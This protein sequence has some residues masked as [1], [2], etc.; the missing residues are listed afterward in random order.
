M[1][2]CMYVLLPPAF[3][4]DQNQILFPAP[5]SYTKTK[6]SFWRKNL[7]DSLPLRLQ[8]N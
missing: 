4:G 8:T 7:R 5:L 3:F 1:L 2:Y 6:A